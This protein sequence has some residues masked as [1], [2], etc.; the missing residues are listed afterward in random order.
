MILRISDGEKEP[1]NAIIDSDDVCCTPSTFRILKMIP[2][3]NII[4]DFWSNNNVQLDTIFAGLQNC[5]ALL[6]MFQN[7]ENQSITHIDTN[8]VNYN[9]Q[10]AVLPVRPLKAMLMLF[11]NY[12]DEAGFTLKSSDLTYIKE[13]YFEAVRRD[14]YPEKN[15]RLNTV[16]LYDNLKDAEMACHNVSRCKTTKYCEVEIVETRSLDSYD[17]QWLADIRSNCIIKEAFNAAKNY[18]DGKMTQNPKTEILFSGKYILKEL[19]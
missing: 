1:I 9:E 14:C 16:I 15:G 5:D 2:V 4:Y 7:L 10:L 6:R 8:F 3:F 18:W 19:K 13:Y 11:K 17:S 12:R